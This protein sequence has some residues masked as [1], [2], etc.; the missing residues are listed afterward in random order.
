[1]KWTM[2]YPG[3]YVCEHEGHQWQATKLHTIWALW[4]NKVRLSTDFKTLR[5][6]KERAAYWMQY[7]R[8]EG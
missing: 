1:M 6:A 3:S 2:E 4:H 5:L 8:G 7:Q